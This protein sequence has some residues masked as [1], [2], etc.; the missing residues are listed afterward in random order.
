MPNE[1]RNREERPVREERPAREELI[2]PENL[3]IFEDKT[4]E[5]G[6]AYDYRIVAVSVEKADVESDPVDRSAVE[7]P[8]D[9]YSF[10]ESVLPGGQGRIRIY[11]HDF[12]R[13]Q[14]GANP[15]PSNTATLSPG[16]RIETSV[17]L[18]DEKGKTVI[19]KLDTGA[20]L[21]DCAA[22]VPI[23]R[24]S[25]GTNGVLLR[26]ASSPRILYL[27]AKDRLRFK[28]RETPPKF[29]AEGPTK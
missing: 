27:D 26:P 22:S 23:F 28:Y 19:E 21:I 1:A 9:M 15:W 18:K 29:T 4:C 5:P 17:S 7:L 13:R 14:P 12:K 24:A 16:D 10:L 20:M 6:Q 8:A 25:A 3:C 11:K 2:V